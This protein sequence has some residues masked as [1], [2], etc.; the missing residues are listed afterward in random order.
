MNTG[1]VTTAAFLSDERTASKREDGGRE[2][3]INWEDDATVLR[4]T[5]DR[6]ESSGHGVA[7]LPREQVDCVCRLQNCRLELR[8]ERRRLEG[9][10][11]H[12]NLLYRKECLKPVEKMIASALALGCEYIPRES[13][14]A[15]TR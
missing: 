14:T 8:Y 2:V 5:L 3:S 15:P 10:P 1:K 11:Y 6:R 4:F 9:N 7:R 12:G 13:P